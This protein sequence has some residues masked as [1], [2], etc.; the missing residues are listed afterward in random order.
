MNE[1]GLVNPL[2]LSLNFAV[3]IAYLLSSCCWWRNS[4]RALPYWRLDE[5]QAF[6]SLAFLH[7]VCTSGLNI[8]FLVNN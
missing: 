6:L 1:N 8:A 4:I 3:N 7:A 2:I 5:C